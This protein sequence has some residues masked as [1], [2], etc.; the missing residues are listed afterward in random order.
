MV[1]IEVTTPVGTADMRVEVK[2]SGSML[3]IANEF[4]AGVAEAMGQIA[5]ELLTNEASFEEK[6]DVCI[7]DIRNRAVKIW[8]GGHKHEKD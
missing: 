4:V 3:D 2:L 8:E 6:V 1:K 5:G 7:K